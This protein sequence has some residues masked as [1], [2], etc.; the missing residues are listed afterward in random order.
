MTNV[1]TRR[2][3][4]TVLAGVLFATMTA[5]P[6]SASPSVRG[7]LLPV[8]AAGPGEQ[9]AITGVDVSPLGLVGGTAR[10]TATGPDGNIAIVETPYRWAELPRLGWQGQQLMLP[11]GATSGAVGGLAD[12]GEAAGQVTLNGVT[13]AARWSLSGRS[14]TLTGGDRSVGGAVDPRGATWG[15]STG[16]ADLIS[17]Q[18]EL[19]TREGVRTP[20]SGTPELDAG[21]RRNVVSVGAD[22][23]VVV[24]VIS[25]AG[26]G[27]TGRPVLW[28]NG[29]TVQLPV[30]GNVFLGAPCVSRVQADGSVVASGF[31]VT[32]GAPR[33]VLL[34]HTGGVPGTN[35]IL[36]EAP[37]PGSPVSG[38][39]CPSGQT[40][41]NLA[42][43][44]GV[45]GWTADAA[46][47]RQ[48]AYWNAANVPT[49]VPLADGERSA[50]GVVAARGGRM[51]ILAEG[52]DGRNR[53]SLWRNG[54]RTALPAPSGWTV[55]SVV[56]L[57]EHGLLIANVQD[58]AGTVRPAAW[59]V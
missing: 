45:A 42:A 57:T 47:L 38:L 24:G 16:G 46:G 37:V 51:V 26:Q 19:V 48:A 58:E 44:G 32:G 1:K 50:Q 9:L 40:V 41:N 6:A 35:V 4:T 39:V 12:I 49:V 31:A 53:M 55:R 59:H 34:R 56:E 15:V 22:G 28:K 7:Q 54:V 17:G 30:F 43:D 2:L 14:V 10:V 13:R 23:T 27:T 11:P 18:A 25:G 33:Y 21:Y 29:A 5:S 52:T 20:L 8:P 3:T 36:S